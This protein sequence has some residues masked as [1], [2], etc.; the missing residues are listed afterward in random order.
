LFEGAWEGIKEV[1][2]LDKIG[3]FFASVWQGIKNAFGSVADWFKNIFSRAWQAVKNVFSTGGKIFDGIKD[4]IVNAFKAVVNGIIKGINKVI[5]MP[6]KGI[7]KV[8]NTIQNVEIVGIRPFDWLT[9]RAP[10]PQI[11]LLYR[12]GVLKKGQVG[13]LEGNGAEAVVPLEN[14]HKWISKVAQDMA[15]ATGGNSGNVY[16]IEINIE[17]AKYSDERSLAEAVAI[18]IQNMTD[19][20]AAVYA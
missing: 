16:N 6:F 9:W 12:G 7:N 18:E 20:R 8:L 19:R 14:N 11:P 4:G 10:V 1:F 15:K 3:E 13:L 2:S 17:G 5:A